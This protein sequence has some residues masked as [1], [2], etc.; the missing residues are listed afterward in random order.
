MMAGG[1]HTTIGTDVIDG[2]AYAADLKDRVAAEVKV[3]A[4]RGVRP[5][6]A[7]VLVGEN[8]P[9]EAYERRVRRLAE[10]LGCHYVLRGRPRLCQRGREGSGDLPGSRRRRADHRR[11]APAQHRLRRPARRRGGGRSAVAGR[12]DAARRAG[13]GLSLLDFQPHAGLPWQQDRW[14]CLLC[15]PGVGPWVRFATFSS[16]RSP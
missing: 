15:A 7:T 4:R 11:L 14:V 13:L 2:R 9:A 8:Y 1:A 12:H 3:L 16:P 10:E 5:G 6:L